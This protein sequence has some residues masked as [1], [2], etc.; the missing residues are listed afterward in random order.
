VQ[1]DP[2]VDR[3]LA[4][5]G[6]RRGEVRREG[7]PF[8]LCPDGRSDRRLNGWFSSAEM[9]PLGLLTWKKYATSLRVWLNFLEVMGVAWDRASPEL[10]E[11]FK[12]WRIQDPGNR[13]R[14]QPGTVGTDLVAVKLFYEWAAR[15]HGLVSPVGMRRV[16]VR[17]TGAVEKIAAAPAARRDRDVKWFDPDGYA[18]YRDLGLLGLTAEGA[19]DPSWRGRNPQRDAAFAD[20]LYRTGLRLT[21]WASVLDIELPGDD[22]SRL[23]YTCRL[24]DAVAKGRI[25]RKFWMPRVALTE[26]LSYVEGERAAAVARARAAGRY[27][28]LD[29]AHVLLRMLGRRRVELCRPDGRRETV[30]LDSLAPQERRRL[31][32]ETSAG[33]EPVAVWLNEDGMPRAP[34]GWHHT[35]ETANRRLARMGLTGFAGAAHMLRHSFALR[36]FAVGRLLYGRRLAHLSEEETKDFREQ[37]GSTWNLVQTLLGHR[38]PQTTMEVYLEPFRSLEVELLLAHIEGVA[39]SA[40]LRELFAGDR[41]VLGD[42]LAYPAAG[43]AEES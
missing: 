30:S 43:E 24:A 14:V 41:R 10:V 42:P 20:G 29:E 22:P 21:E 36:W 11:A 33:L 12:V 19:D 39:A 26:V 27:E 35:F 31:L 38:N 13:R 23:F 8:L 2:L 16:F 25:G 28:R 17:G 4:V 7:Q 15:A 18:R 37:F 5:L 6:D 32:R 34:H 9:R 40:L 1:G 3:A